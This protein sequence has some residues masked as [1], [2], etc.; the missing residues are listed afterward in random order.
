MEKNIIPSISLI[1]D[2]PVVVTN[3][4]YQPYVSNGKELDLWGVMDELSDFDKVH[5]LDLDG[6]EFNKPQTES[7]RKIGS[8][9]EVWVDIGARGPEGITDSFIAG[10]DKTVIATKTIRSLKGILESIDLSDQLVLSIDYKDGLISPSEE[11]KKMG[12]EG[13]VELALNKDFDEIIFADLG[14]KRFDERALRSIPEGDY[15]LF[16]GGASLDEIGYIH[17]GN[18]EG[19]ILGLR[20]AIRWQRN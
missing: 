11:I 17:H 7:I 1:D 5:L 20:E 15:E 4:T 6:I 16:I 2:K 19:Y 14:E 12:V 9:K 13:I 3:G 18:I 10:A 8:R